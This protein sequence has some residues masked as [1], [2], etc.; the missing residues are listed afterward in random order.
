[1]AGSVDE[2]ED[3]NT[4]WRDQYQGLDRERAW[5]NGHVCVCLSFWLVAT[6]REP[7]HDLTSRGPR[8]LLR[9]NAVES[10]LNRLL[11]LKFHHLSFLPAVHMGSL[12][13]TKPRRHDPYNL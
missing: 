4:Q 11:P 2:L 5:F 3:Q 13:K 9:L 12:V 10:E 7:S 1:M 6:Q 8:V